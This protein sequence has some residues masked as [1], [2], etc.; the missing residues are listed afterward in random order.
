MSLGYTHYV[1]SRVHRDRERTRET[2]RD[3]LAFSNP[4]R[5]SAT[6]PHCL[7]GVLS[8]PLHS[9]F[10]T[11]TSPPNMHISTADWIEGFHPTRLLAAFFWPIKCYST[12]FRA[13]MVFTFPE[14]SHMNN[15]F[16]SSRFSPRFHPLLSFFS[17]LFLFHQR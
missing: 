7:V 13:C 16:V 15:A 11:T 5:F 10:H 9:L 14:I 2:G 3:S 1:S 4:P 8:T 12:L 6:L 17:F